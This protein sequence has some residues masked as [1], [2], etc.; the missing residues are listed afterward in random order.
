[1]AHFAKIENG[2]VTDIIVIRN[3]DCENLDFPSSEPVGQQYIKSIGLDGYWIQT[4]YNGNFRKRYAG[5]GYSYDPNLDVFIE[6]KPYPSWILD[7]NNLF[8]TSPVP[9]PK[10]TNDLY[11]W[12]EE[13]KKWIIYKK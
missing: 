6:P 3:E 12:D 8:W 4:S 10:N 13:N 1:M 9:Y 5:I 2:K 11:T 7:S